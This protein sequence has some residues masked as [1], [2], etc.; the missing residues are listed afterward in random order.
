MSKQYFNPFHKGSAWK[1]F[2]EVIE[3]FIDPF[4][5]DS[6][7]IQTGELASNKPIKLNLSLTEE[8]KLI[9]EDTNKGSD[10]EAQLNTKSI[11]GKKFT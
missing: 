9:N 1:N 4:I 6:A 2:R 8:K 5:P 11:S 3:S 7:A 10:P